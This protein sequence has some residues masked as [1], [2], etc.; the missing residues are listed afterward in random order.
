MDRCF[1]IAEKRSE[2]AEVVV[3]KRKH[4]L[5]TLSIAGSHIGL[6]SSFTTMSVLPIWLSG[7]AL[8]W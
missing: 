3:E 4:T 7:R 5:C 6:R 1:D 8:P 2:Q